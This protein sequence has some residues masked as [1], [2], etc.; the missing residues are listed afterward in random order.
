MTL[1]V[2]IAGA[3][4][5]MGIQLLKAVRSDDALSLSHGLVRKGTLEG[6]QEHLR[7]N[8]LGALVDQLTPDIDIF[9]KNADVIIDFTGPALSLGLAEHANG[10]VCGTTGFS[11]AQF[12]TLQEAAKRIPILWAPNMSIGVNALMALVEKAAASL[13]TGYDIEITEMHHKHKKDAPSGTALGLGRAAAKGRDV[14]LDEVAEYARDGITG[15]R[16]KGTIGFTALRGGDVIGD[17]TV[18]FAGP[19]ERIELSHKASNR[20]IYAQGAIRAAKWLAGKPAG[21]YSMQD[22]L[23]L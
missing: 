19:G 1:Q 7:H 9:T 16:T 3:S 11:E 21:F 4:G 17:H 20:A 8:G 15:E 2:G 6:A 10:L 23:G 12:A 22:M 14:A 13:D 18:C 5:R